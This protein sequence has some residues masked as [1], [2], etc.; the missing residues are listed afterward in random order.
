MDL[1]EGLIMIDPE[2]G[3]WLVTFAS[4]ELDDDPDSPTEGTYVDVVTLV[5][6]R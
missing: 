1:T 5:F 4:Q 6:Q 2:G 3:E